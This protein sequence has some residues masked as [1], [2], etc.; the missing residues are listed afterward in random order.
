MS[1]GVWRMPTCIKDHVTVH[2]SHLGGSSD[3]D[4]ACSLHCVHVIFSE[5]L[6]YLHMENIRE[7]SFH[8]STLP[9]EQHCPAK[10]DPR[11]GRRSFL[12]VDRS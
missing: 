9:Q 5:S 1:G 4:I 2:S 7:A 10:A 6:H 11:L 12:L 3:H 8:A